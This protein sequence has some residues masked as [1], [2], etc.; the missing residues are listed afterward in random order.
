MRERSGLTL[1][2]ASRLTGVAI[3]TLSKIEN[4]KMSPTFDVVTRIMKGLRISAA[5]LFKDSGDPGVDRPAAVDRRQDPIVISIPGA[6]Y[7]V[8]CAD[9][10][11]KEMFPTIVTL[12]A[13]AHH[14]LL[15]HAG[16]EFVMVLAGALEIALKDREP[17]RLK[18]GECLYFDSTV[19]HSF[20][21]VGG[22]PARFLAVS[23]R[24]VLE[25]EDYQDGGCATAAQRLRRLIL[26]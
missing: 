6:D 23:N 24:T 20:C 22:K 11:S 26:K 2:E 8:L 14:E 17:I 10:L 18:R 3:S 13:G 9:S 4:G 15:A 12:R 1:D 25:G 5:F 7:E 19:P 16:E 21:A